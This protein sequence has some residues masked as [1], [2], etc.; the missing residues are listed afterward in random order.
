MTET[1]KEIIARALAAH[2]FRTRGPFEGELQYREALAK[3]L[4]RFD[5]ALAQEVAVGC[6]QADWTPEQVDQFRRRIEGLR[7]PHDGPPPPVIT[8]MDGGKAEPTEAALLEMARRG[9]EW[10]ITFRQTDPTK[11]MAII[12]SV[13]LM[14]GQVWLTPSAATGER[15]AVLKALAQRMPVFG[16]TL[17]FDAFCHGITVGGAATKTDALIMHVGTRERRIAMVRPYLVRN[18][19]V[20]W[21]PARPDMEGKDMAHDPYAGIFVSVPE[22]TG[23]PS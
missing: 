4:T 14:D 9:L 6:A 8:M 16:F 3:H 1:L 11:E 7:G 2:P 13:L 21:E 20:K 10:G 17:L 5:W 23:K 12:A 19:R 15:V 18:N 22:P